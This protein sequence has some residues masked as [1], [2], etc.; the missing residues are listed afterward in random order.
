[1]KKDDL[2]IAAVVVTFNR[3][4]LLKECLQALL[5][6]TRPLDEIIV[7]DNASSDGTNQMVRSE[8]PQV[9]YVR[10]PENIGGA[11]GFHEG[12][13]LAY[14]KGH[15]WIWVMD[16]DA[17]PAIDALE[18][19]LKFEHL[20]EEDVYALAST[21]INSN[22]RICA[23]HRRLFDLRKAQEIPIPIEY[24]KKENFEVDTASFVGM[25]VSRKA[26]TKLGPP[27]KDFFI[28]YDDT[29]YSLRIRSFEGRIITLSKSKI[30]HTKEE[31][32]RMKTRKVPLSWR[33]YYGHRN[34]IYTYKKY[35]HLGARFY[36]EMLIKAIKTQLGIVLFRPHKLAS[37]KILW[38]SL[39]DGFKGKLGKELLP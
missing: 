30:M 14:E 9:T 18:Q 37:T 29:E 19:L 33:Y 8:F 1:M 22:G 21:V 32:Q 38:K 24:Y 23:T 31:T 13:K 4:E 7:I 34:K 25:L 3:K 20:Q 11:G 15:D 35:G 27:L 2:R 39:L 28:Y 17:I 26:M 10:L 16:D 12:M 6:Q 36:I 5:R